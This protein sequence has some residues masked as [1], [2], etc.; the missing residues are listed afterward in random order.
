MQD[1]RKLT[2]EQQERLTK[3]LEEMQHEMFVLT[4]KGFGFAIA[5]A[6]P[7]VGL[8]ILAGVQDTS[9][10]MLAGLLTWVYINVVYIGPNTREIGAR[11]GKE[12]E[13]IRDFLRRPD[14]K[15]E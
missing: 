6:F 15:E 1:P 9:F 14:S 10:P 2:P 13:E 8:S 5:S 4:L 12:I 3:A 7:I 11:Y